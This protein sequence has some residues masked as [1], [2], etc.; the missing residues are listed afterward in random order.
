MLRALSAILPILLLLSILPLPS[1]SQA[2]PSTCAICPITACTNVLPNTSSI[3]LQIPQTDL[4]TGGQFCT[5]LNAD[6]GYWARTAPTQ[7]CV[8]QVAAFGCTVM[9]AV[10]ATE[11]NCNASSIGQ[12]LPGFSQQFTAGCQQELGCLATLVGM[13]L[14]QLHACDNFTAF[15][16]ALPVMAALIPAAVVSSST[17]AGMVGNAAASAT[18]PTRLGWTVVLLAVVVWFVSSLK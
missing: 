13:E 5:A 14:V 6:L 7:A 8:A 3:T 9:A 18:S 17:A 16:D 10:N 1:F 2:A 4:G 12:G 11:T 15:L